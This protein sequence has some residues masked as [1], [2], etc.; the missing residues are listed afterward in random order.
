MQGGDQY[1]SAL[2]LQLASKH[3]SKGE[4]NQN[5]QQ[6][7]LI[8]QP[9]HLYRHFSIIKCFIQLGDSL[10]HREK[11]R[12]AQRLSSHIESCKTSPGFCVQCPR[13]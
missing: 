11:K 9:P 8:H 2:K 5:H 12:V 3:I 7:E 6:Q 13:D 10:G 4:K 1:H